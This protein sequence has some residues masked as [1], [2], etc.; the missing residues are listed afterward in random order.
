VQADRVASAGAI[1]QRYRSWVVLK[2]N[3]S[4]IA[5]PDGKFW[6]NSSGNPGMASAEWATR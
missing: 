5:A 6:I 2:G 4:V 3:G 1:A